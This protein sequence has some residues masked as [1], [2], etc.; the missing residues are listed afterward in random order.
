MPIEKLLDFHTIGWD[1]DQTLV[2][3]R[4]SHRMWEFIR[5]TPDKLHFI[6]TFRSHGDQYFV[7][8]ELRL[9]GGPGRDAF[10]GVFNVPDMVWDRYARKD[11]RRKY[12]PDMERCR[13]DDEYEYWKA[14]TCK[15]HDIPVLVDDMTAH[16]AEGCEK[17][18]IIH[19]HPDDLW[20]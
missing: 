1:F 3:D 13:I 9:A 16:V 12:M 2:G 15:A 10:A 18:G 17:Y 8:D 19:F 6:V 20:A 14:R 11:Y 4:N 7:W 5:E